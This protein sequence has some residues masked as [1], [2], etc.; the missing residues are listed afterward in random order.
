MMLWEQMAESEKRENILRQ[1]LVISQ[2]SLS[3]SEKM[4]EK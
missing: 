2:Q 4:I 1:E 3:N